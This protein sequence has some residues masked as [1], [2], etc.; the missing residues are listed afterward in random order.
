MARQVRAEV[1]RAA[2]LSAAADVFSRLGYANA[3]LSEIIDQSGVTKGALYFHFASKE[4]LAR[5]VIDEG[6]MR[7]S[8]ACTALRDGRAPALEAIIGLSYLRIEVAASDPI[9]AAMFRLH[10]E[11]GDHRGTGQNV[12]ALWQ[13]D[14]QELAA[15]AYAEGDIV[16]EGD[17]ATVGTFLL[18]TLMGV[19]GVAYATGAVD[20][21]PRRIERVWYFIL[22]SL[23][24]QSKLVYFREFAARRLLR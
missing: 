20:E 10:C 13:A 18:E 16:A 4:E 1:T 2:V 23:V 24:D 6:Q 5:G 15:R 8:E 17:A 9:I 11:I 19:R 3:S 14:Y 21:L 7:L 12:V 22:P